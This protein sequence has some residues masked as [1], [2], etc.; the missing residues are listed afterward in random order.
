MT[1]S[2][3]GDGLPKKVGRVNCACT[4]GNRFLQVICGRVDAPVEWMFR[5]GVCEVGGEVRSV[6][7]GWEKIELVSEKFFAGCDYRRSGMRRWR[8]LE[9]HSASVRFT[10]FYCCELVL[11]AFT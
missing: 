3:R 9:L 10:S 4:A 5:I 1:G 7:L 8:G 11:F 2:D 6:W